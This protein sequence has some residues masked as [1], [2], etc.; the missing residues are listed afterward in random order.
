M[1]SPG[2]KTAVAS[3]A[4]LMLALSGCGGGTEANGDGP[5]KE[6]V[7]GAGVVPQSF[8]PAQSREAQ[9]VQYFQ[10]VFDSLVRRLPSG[11]TTGMLATGWEYTRDNTRL[12]LELREDVG[13][14]DGTAFDA[15]VAKANID[16]F[17]K[18]GGPLSGSLGAVKETTATDD[19][20]LVIDLSSPDPSLVYNLGGPA[21]LMQSTK[22]FDNP[23]VAT[24][25]VG[26]GPYV[27]DRKLTTPGAKYVYTANKDYWNPGLRKFD[28]IVI[29]PMADENAR[30]NALRSGQIDGAIGT[31]KTVS[32]VEAVKALTVHTV[33]GDWQGLSLFDRGGEKVQAL[34]DVRVRRAINHAIDKKAILK[35]VGLGYGET[36][37]QIFNPSSEAFVKE[38]DDRYEYDVKK[39]ESL[40][41]E[42]GY[43]DGFSLKMPSSSDIDPAIPQVVSDQLAVVGIKVNW[44]NVPSA[45]YQPEQQSGKYSAAYTAFGQQ[46]VS[47]GNVSQLVTEKGPWNVFGS[48]DDKIDGLL[49]KITT[50]SGDGAEAAYQELNTYLVEH[51][52]FSP[53]YRIEQPYYTGPDVT[54]EMQNGQAVPSL[55]NY[56][57]AK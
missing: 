31:A 17:R 32:Q 30:L 20:T 9:F 48:Q 36:T 29:E 19:T 51:A 2:R 21:G 35:K 25:P 3:V 39:A 13:F 14:S 28:R 5:V 8:D 50:S 34:G 27:L 45:Q 57:P 43:A 49:S 7:L 12:T 54:V 1:H 40:L 18:A 33:S 15:E 37:S 22:Q 38:L 10:P 4:A 6:L 41:A 44:T 53:W 23:D 16:R 52:W 11:E 46:V 24:Q 55:Y 42:A 26:S 56:A 47:W